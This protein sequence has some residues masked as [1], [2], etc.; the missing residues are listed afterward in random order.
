MPLRTVT[1]RGEAGSIL[2]VPIDIEILAPSLPSAMT[3]LFASDVR[4]VEAVYEHVRED[5][6]IP[7]PEVHVLLADDLTS[8][9]NRLSTHARYGSPFASDR[10]GGVVAGKNLDLAGDASRVAIVFDATLW[11]GAELPENRLSLLH[12]VAHELAHPLIERARHAS[13]ALDGVLLPSVTGTEI[14]RS[15]GRISSGE[16][17][18]DRLAEL[19]VGQLIT[20][21][22]GAEQT[23]PGCTWDVIGDAWLTTLRSVLADAHPAWPDTVQ[24]YREHRISLDAMWTTIVTAVDQTLTLLIHAQASADAADDLGVGVGDLLARPDLASLP[25]VTQWLA[26]P[27]AAYLDTMRTSPLLSTL[28]D[29]PTAEDE[30]IGSGTAAVVEIWERLGIRTVERDE[31]QLELQVSDPRR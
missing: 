10:L 2:V 15:M 9:V 6:G 28:E 23:R 26:E 3:D 22:V 13:G 11:A 27:W 14:A 24:A 30:V 4:F 19:V 16:Y 17:R 25:A 21:G 7:R 12:L 8:E 31:R 1:H 29:T 5:M 20:V 18:A